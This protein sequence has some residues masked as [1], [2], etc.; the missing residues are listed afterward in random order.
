MKGCVQ[1]HMCGRNSKET[2]LRRT[3]EHTHSQIQGD[4]E[5]QAKTFKQNVMGPQEPLQ[6]LDQTM[7]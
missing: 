7:I 3:K 5:S 2:N 6:V 1:T 4:L